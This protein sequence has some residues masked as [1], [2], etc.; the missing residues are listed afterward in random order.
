MNSKKMCV[1][2]LEEYPQKKVSTCLNCLESGITCHNCEL[3][4][5]EANNDPIKCTICKE[6]TKQNISG[7]ILKKI[8]KE[9][10]TDIVENT[11]TFYT[12]F[13][14]YPIL[15]TIFITMVILI[16]MCILLIIY[17]IYWCIKN[18]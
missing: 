3:K 1:I 18:C 13:K 2:C 10:S 14:K 4:W 11:L 5:T 12:L 7:Q 6:N 17:G 15:L 9:Q 16:L 8:N